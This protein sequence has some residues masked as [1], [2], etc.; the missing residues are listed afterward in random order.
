[1]PAGQRLRRWLACVDE[2]RETRA[3]L[4]LGRFRAPV[5]GWIVTR[6][7]RG[8]R[9]FCDE[10]RAYDLATGA[11]YVASSCGREVLTE[12]GSH[13]DRDATDRTRRLSFTA[14]Q[15]P[16]DALREAAL[17]AMVASWSEEALAD[18]VTTELLPAN[19]PLEWDDDGITMRGISRCGGPL[20]TW[21]WV[22]GS[23][24]IARGTSDG[25][26]SEYADELWEATDARLAPGC[27]LA[28]LPVIVTP[29]PRPGTPGWIFD[30][31]AIAL[32]AHARSSCA[33]PPATWSRSPNI[34]PE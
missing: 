14:G 9:A 24:T 19:V 27:P 7:H 11:A 23:R 2:A 18:E 32:S 34:T 22:D 28:A 10:L 12:D 29:P 3:A 30:D 31:L 13:R 33:I 4:P 15:V 25:A 8:A 1:M 5:T 16:L 21:E 26:V 6:S 20:P 17:I